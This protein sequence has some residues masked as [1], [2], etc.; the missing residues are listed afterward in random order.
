MEIGK[1]ADN[2]MRVWKTERAHTRKRESMDIVG[3]LKE[4]LC[5]L[6]CNYGCDVMSA[7]GLVVLSNLYIFLSK[8][9]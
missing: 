5:D 4:D 2:D 1:S 7:G 3:W 8:F 9:Q 6:A